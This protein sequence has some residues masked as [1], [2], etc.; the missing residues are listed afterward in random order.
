MFA[1]VLRAGSATHFVKVNRAA[2]RTDDSVGAR[3]QSRVPLWAI[4]ALAVAFFV[5]G[6]LLVRALEPLGGVRRAYGAPAS[7]RPPLEE[8]RAMRRDAFARA[9]KITAIAAGP[10]LLAVV[11]GAVALLA[12]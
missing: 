5:C 7:D 4:P 10:V 9:W 6:S 8:L 2:V 12:E 11:G 1:I 3:I